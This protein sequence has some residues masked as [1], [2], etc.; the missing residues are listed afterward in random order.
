M[1][2]RHAGGER[3]I[4]VALDFGDLDFAAHTFPALSTVRIDRRG[5]G[6]LAAEAMLARMEGRSDMEKV[7]DTGFEVIEREST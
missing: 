5:I 7:L 6:R 3:V 4:L 1:F 2:E